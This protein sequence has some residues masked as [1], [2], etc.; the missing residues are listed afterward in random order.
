MK[1]LVVVM[2]ILFAGISVQAQEKKSKN[3]KYELEVK[4]NC[5][6][7]KKRIEKAA[8]GVKGVKSAEWHADH[9]DLHLVIDENKCSLDDVR[10]AVAGSGHDTDTLK[11]T[12]EAY[13][14][15]HSCCK[16]DREAETEHSEH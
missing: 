9:Q 1:K 11:A 15:L 12:D 6:D 10:K 5:G 3:A 8:Y 2:L 16:Y 14:G 13:D 7:C 4:G